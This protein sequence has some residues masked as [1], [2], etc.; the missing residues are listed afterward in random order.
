MSLESVAGGRE[1][2][3]LRLVTDVLRSFADATT[4]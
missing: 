1:E 4:D 3:R 2:S